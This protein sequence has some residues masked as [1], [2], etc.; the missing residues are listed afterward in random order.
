MYLDRKS[1][2]QLLAYP[3]REQHI[4]VHQKAV[5]YS[6]KLTG[7]NPYYLVLIGQQLISHLNENP[8][9]QLISE[10][11]IKA[12]VESIIDAGAMHN[13]LFY[14]DELQ[15]DEE[16]HIVEAIVDITSRI[17]QPITSLKKIAEWLG[18]PSNEIRPQL[19]RLRNGLILNEYRQAR[20]PSIPYYALKIELVQR[21][22]AHNRWF[23]TVQ[24][25]RA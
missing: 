11:D 13:F 5:A 6:I 4:E 17:D 10:E 23:F 1:A 12:A 8:E 22:M 19:E 9:Q 16:L 7:G 18:R 24:K 25:R 2:E 3:L 15:N 20:A 21:W 14:H